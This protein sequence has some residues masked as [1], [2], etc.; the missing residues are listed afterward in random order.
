MTPF[1]FHLEKVLE[2][3]TTQLELE[4]ARFK[5]AAAA[6]ASLDRAR[7]E[8]EATSVRAELE[9]RQWHEVAGRDLSA[10]GDFRRHIQA[11]QR[12]LSVRRAERQKALETQETAMLAARRRCRLLE[13]LKERRRTE[14]QA[15]FDREV[16]ELASESFLA[17][18]A[19]RES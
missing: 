6:V 7:A 11:Q 17:G 5:Q 3:R 2:W 13:R 9:V 12:A 4:E 15:G 19:H 10:L 14:W 8:I 1:R 18:W 16:E